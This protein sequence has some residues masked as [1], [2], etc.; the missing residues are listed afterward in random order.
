[1]Q[2]WGVLIPV[3]NTG[4]TPKGATF[5]DITDGTSNTIVVGERPPSHDMEF[6]WGYAGW[7]ASGNSDCDTL[8][9]VNELNDKAAGTE[10]DSCPT[11]PYQFTQGNINNPCDQFHFWSMHTAGANFLF[12]DG[13]VKFMP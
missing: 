4:Q 7:G 9:G 6:G 2:A 11:G 8:L 1:P 13:S 5:G 10:S 12:G 3:A